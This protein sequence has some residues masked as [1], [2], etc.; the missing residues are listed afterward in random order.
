MTVQEETFRLLAREIHDEFGQVLTAMGAMVARVE[1]KLPASEDRSRADLREVREI[2]QRTL[3]RARTMSQMLHPPVLDDYG[4]ERS[5]EW[6]LGQFQRQ[7]GIE[8][9][10]EKTGSGPL[11]RAEAAIHVYRIVQEALS[12]VARHAGVREAWVRAHYAPDRIQM[13]VEDHGGGMPATMR[14]GSIG[15]VAMRE[16]AGLLQGKIEFSRPQAGGT[17]V[18]LNVPLPAGREKP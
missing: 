2:A 5:V 9:H 18:E 16:R 4:L 11:V 13:E 17:R 14:P 12:N 6:Y 1:K 7:S 8:V 3:E 10:Y 15:L